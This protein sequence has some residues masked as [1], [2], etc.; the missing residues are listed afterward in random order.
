MR[1]VVPNYRNTEHVAQH[2]PSLKLL[3]NS[4][5]LKGLDWRYG[6]RYTIFYIDPL[7]PYQS[8]T[9]HS[10]REQFQSERYS[11]TSTLTP[12]TSPTTARQLPHAWS[13]SAGS[14]ISK[15]RRRFTEI[16][17][18]SN[19]YFKRWVRLQNSLNDHTVSHA[20]IFVI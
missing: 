14:L 15:P 13:S 17:S 12:C 1:S 20:R 5:D 3:P 9:L 4:T 8:Q 18:H 10:I 19:S 11:P 2:I 7:F 6:T 16:P